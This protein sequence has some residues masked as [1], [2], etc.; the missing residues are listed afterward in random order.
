MDTYSVNV[1]IF[2]HDHDIVC[3][4]TNVYNIFIYLMRGKLG[5]SRGTGAGG[6]WGVGGENIEEM[7]F[8]YT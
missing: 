7:S 3:G 1:Y 4:E 6:D 2:T 8:F 5:M